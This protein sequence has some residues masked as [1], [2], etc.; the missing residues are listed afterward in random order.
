MKNIYTLVG[1]LLLC[2]I[3][4]NN[5][6]LAQNTEK[7]RME[8]QRDSLAHIVSEKVYLQIDEKNALKLFDEEPSFG[9]F[10]DNYFT[11]GIPV[12]QQINHKT[13]DAKF[14]ISIRQRLTKSILPFNT[15]LY[16]TY[17][18]KSF[19]DI[20]RTSLPFR[21]NNFNPGLSIGKP[22][23][24]NN[25][26]KGIAIF[27][28]EHESNGRDSIDSRDWNY[29]SFSFTHF[30]NMRFS[31]ETKVWAGWVDKNENPKLLRY[32]GY[33]L[34]AIN[35]QSADERLWCSLI[36]YPRN[37]FI[38]FNTITEFNYKL[39]KQDNQYLFIQ[40][41]QGYGENLL[42]YRKYKCMLRFGLCIKPRW[43]NYY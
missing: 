38:N 9:I 23:I 22:I 20:Y 8:E 16:V 13:A 7:K 26:L 39:R 31:A 10:R 6:S 32:K 30:F 24:R 11:T 29:F 5:A 27:S 36:L 15:F 28:F 1:I 4:L 14:Q 2:F 21:D 34:L 42:E 41:Y 37:K 19:W 33:G 35:Y 12:N 18:Q 17:T 25:R 3:G 40:F 43:F